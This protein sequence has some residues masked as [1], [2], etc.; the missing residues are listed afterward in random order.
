LTARSPPHAPAVD[1]TA[2]RRGAGAVVAGVGALVLFGWWR[3]LDV[4]TRVVP[5]LVTLKPNE[6]AALVLVGSGL[7]LAAPRRL[8]WARRLILVG[9]GAVLVLLAGATV[10]QDL[11]GAALAI[12]Q[13]LFADQV[14]PIMTGSPGRMSPFSGLAV[15]LLGIA[16]LMTPVRS[17]SA[18]LVAQG[19]ALIAF[20]VGLSGLVSYAYGLA[21]SPLPRDW[22]AMSLHGCIALLIAASAALLLREDVGIGALLVSGT[23]A[24]RILRALTP[25]AITLPLAIGALLSQATADAQL[26]PPVAHALLGLSTA[27]LLT[28]LVFRTAARISS[29][30]EQRQRAE[31][32]FE[33]TFEN[34]DVGLAELDSRGQW[35]NANGRLLELLGCD[36]AALKH[37]TLF[38]LV[39]PDD[40]ASLRQEV[41]RLVAGAVPTV[42]GERR[43]LARDG[44]RIWV[45]LRLAA[46]RAFDDGPIRLAAAIQDRRALRAAL[47][48]LRVRERALESAGSGVVITDSRAEGHPIIYVN[49]TFERITGFSRSEVLGQ[50]SRFLNRYARSQPELDELRAALAS[51]RECTVVL[52]NHRKDGTPFWNQLTVAPVR[53]EAGAVSHYVGVQDDV[54]SRVEREADR[55]RALGDAV[56]RRDEATAESRAKD[57]FLSLV[58]H[59]LRSPLNAISGWISVLKAHPDQTTADKATEIIERSVSAQ[60][61]LINDLL[62]V[63]RMVSGSFEIEERLFDLATVVAA[64]VEALQPVAATRGIRLR[65]HEAIKTAFLRGDEERIA[66]VVRNLI[67]NAVKFSAD[68]GEVRAQLTLDGEGLSI[69]VED[70]GQ[71]IPSD[72]LPHIFE[73]FRQGEALRRQGLGL[74]LAIAANIVERHRG[75]IE[76]RSDGEGRGARFEV[77]LPAIEAIETVSSRQ[78]PVVLGR[79]TSER[80]LLVDDDVGFVEALRLLLVEEGHRVFTAMSVAQAREVLAHHPV[81]IVITDIQLPDGTGFDLIRDV[82]A[83]AQSNG[84]CRPFVVAVSGMDD[85]ADRRR[86][87]EAGFD[88]WLGKPVDFR[89]LLETLRG[90]ARTGQK[91]LLLDGDS[92]SAELLASLLARRGHEVTIGAV[93][94]RAREDLPEQIRGLAPDAVIVNAATLGARAAEI[95]ESL[96]DLQEAGD[97]RLVALVPSSEAA[98]L[99]GLADAVLT[100]PVDLDLLCRELARRE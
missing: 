39:E 63:S 64:T 44:G 67:D 35:L 6:A 43:L 94:A 14:D 28:L 10:A 29:E 2:F 71:G 1:A 46:W 33:S 81:E 26:D 30:Q 82:R 7:L 91:L 87:Q 89:R 37:T 49:E 3:E 76:A 68:G 12:D 88:A 52:L 72:L 25:F 96:S 38:D 4:L 5:G 9:L 21:P 53:D 86:Y 45:E 11:A 99:E 75:R 41:S 16:F 69:V 55:E 61:R 58:S 50:N 18:A 70:D 90:R 8:S 77:R 32:R 42:A 13:R 22:T 56:A 48:G 98:G 73:R 27:V 62:D 34:A 31:R 95:L 36:L 65:Y 92:L 83:M 80:V 85:V 47:E 100:K 59:E 23:I 66:Q 79:T 17:R 51:R 84:D 74:G 40:A 97:V 24:G 57:E 20:V 60:T 15:L 54:T 93:E 78:A 19:S